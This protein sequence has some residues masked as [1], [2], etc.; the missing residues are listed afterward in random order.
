MPKGGKK[1]IAEDL[2]DILEPEVDD[3]YYMAQGYLDTLK[4]HKLREKA[5]GHGFGY[6][7]VNR[8]GI[9]HPIANTLLATGGSGKERNLIYQP[10]E[11]IA[12]KILPTKRTGLNNEGIRVMT[13][14]EWGRLQGFIGYAF[15]DENGIDKFS[16]P[17]GTSKAQQYKQFGNSV[18]I[19]VIQEMASFMLQC[20]DKMNACHKEII[21]KIAAENDA[22]NKRDVIEALN[23]SVNQANYLLRKMV[24]SGEIILINRGR[25]SKYKKPIK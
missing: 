4:R 3:D 11:G 24:Q 6:V 14:T 1:V 21:Q 13:P 7:V 12:G 2:N 18:T 19:P 5:K 10:K 16:F 9:D 15:V 17:D 20:F 23:I 22:F 25:H 8:S